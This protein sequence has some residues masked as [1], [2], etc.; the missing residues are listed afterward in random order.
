[1]AVCEIVFIPDDADEEQV[2]KLK[3]KIDE[4]PGHYKPIPRAESYEGYGD[5]ADF[6]CHC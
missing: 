6:I 3:D 5:M 1:M 4:N 2:G